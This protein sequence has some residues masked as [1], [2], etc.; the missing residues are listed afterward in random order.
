[1][2]DPASMVHAR[3]H[4]TPIFQQNEVL[5]GHDGTPGIV[6]VEIDGMDKVKIFRR[7]DGKTETDTVPFH[8]FMLLEGDGALKDWKGEAALQ[9]LN[10]RGTFNHLALFPDL[11]QLEQAKFHLQKKTGKASS[12]SDLPYWYF[13]DPI[14][15]FLRSPA[16]HFSMV[17]GANTFCMRPAGGISGSFSES[18]RITAASQ[19]NRLQ[20]AD[21]QQELEKPGLR[22]LGDCVAIRMS[23]KGTIFSFRSGIHRS[24]PGSIK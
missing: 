2:I 4:L 23:S 18:D 20:A 6:A 19:T 12:A 14:Q 5:F 17:F 9:K 8:P 3:E 1:M 24:T 10:G 21:F 11:K 15:Q 22:V 16:R 7:Q 13:S